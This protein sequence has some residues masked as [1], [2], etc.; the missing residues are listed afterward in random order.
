VGVRCRADGA[1]TLAHVETETEGA[2]DSVQ[3]SRLIASLVPILLDSF[4]R[5]AASASASPPILRDLSSP[6]VDDAAEAAGAAIVDAPAPAS[7]TGRDALSD[8]A[9]RHRAF[10][11]FLSEV[12]LYG[13]TRKAR[14]ALADQGETL[15]GAAALFELREEMLGGRHTDTDGDGRVPLLED[16]GDLP[17]HASHL[18]ER[19][20]IILASEAA[21][22][23][24]IDAVE[25]V[26]HVVEDV[27]EHRQR[28]TDL[29][30]APATA[31]GYPG[32]AS[33]W[34]CGE[35]FRHVLVAAVKMLSQIDPGMDDG[36]A[37]GR[38][39]HCVQVITGA[40]LD[41]YA[42]DAL[43]VDHGTERGPALVEFHGGYH[44]AKVSCISLLQ[45]HLGDEAAYE[46]SM[47][48]FYFD[49]IV[50]VCNRQKADVHFLGD[51]VRNFMNNKRDS[52][53]VSFAKFILLW[54]MKQN[55]VGEILKLAKYCPEDVDN[56][57]AD[58]PEISW[59]VD[60]ENKRYDRAAT[61]LTKIAY[62]QGKHLDDTCLSLSLAKM[63]LI[64][65]EKKKMASDQ[66][67]SD[68]KAFSEDGLVLVRCQE[69]LFEP[70]HEAN[71]RALSRSELIAE[72]VLALSDASRPQES[73]IAACLA[74]LSAAEV[75][76]GD[77]G[78]ADAPQHAA[79]LWVAAVGGERELW[80]ELAIR[81]GGMA[82]ADLSAALAEMVQC[83]AMEAYEAGRGT[84]ESR[85]DLGF[86][87]ATVR[88]AVLRGVDP[89][90]GRLLEVSCTLCS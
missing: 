69:T 44:R 54:Y 6:D 80:T 76:T 17:S 73:R 65:A 38:L 8:K 36:A 23:S 27:V 7:M 47:T 74:G 26:V 40:C 46:A 67:L 77:S 5:H 63:S 42:E 53:G 85:P 64:L 30:D 14:P 13:R 28:H 60:L 24:P 22:A 35:D 37:D 2:A 20:K 72:A 10:V 12:G 32:Y 39:L 45:R 55:K 11:A 1:G 57:L 61:S 90:V 62:Q 15:A 71:R 3:R 34:R 51:L 18:L 56:F 78:A 41:S 16:L 84:D 43:N 66:V 81:A 83:R 21:D 59:I 19:L 86:G 58:S 52:T 79:A 87:S 89:V 82:D 70:P 29:Y 9:V 25:A 50:N 88:E 33:P 4:D 49:G 75:A 31:P 48:H 68:L